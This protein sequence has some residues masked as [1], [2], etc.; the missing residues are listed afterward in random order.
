MRKVTEEFL[1][2]KKVEI[3]DGLHG[4]Q[5]QNDRSFSVSLPT[6]RMPNMK[7]C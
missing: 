6:G 5:K 7:H 1:N 2:K 3:L 4:W